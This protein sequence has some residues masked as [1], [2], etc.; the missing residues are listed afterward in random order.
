MLAWLTHHLPLFVDHRQPR[1]FI[2]N[3]KLQGVLDTVLQLARVQGG[4]RH[5]LAHD[6][7][8]CQLLGASRAVTAH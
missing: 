1:D 2:Q 3:E 7:V 8:I 4:L 6:A 5:D